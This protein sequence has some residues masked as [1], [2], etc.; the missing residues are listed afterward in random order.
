MIKTYEAF[1][2]N[3][4]YIEDLIDGYLT[5]KTQGR[6][7]L[8]REYE[9]SKNSRAGESIK[10]TRLPARV[11]SVEYLLKGSSMADMRQKLIKLNDIVNVGLAEF[12]FDDE[13]DLLY[14]GYAILTKS[15]DNKNGVNG[16]MEIHC[17][18]PFKYSIIEQEAGV[19]PDDSYS[20]LLDYQGTYESHPTLEVK[21]YEEDEKEEVLTGAG[22]CGYIA[23]FTEDEKILQFGDPDEIDGEAVQGKSETLVSQ[24]FN[25]PNDWGSTAKLLWQENTGK[26]LSNTCQTGE[27]GMSVAEYTTS[28]SFKPTSG[29]LI[30]K[31]KSTVGAPYAFY[32]V[33][34]KVVSRTEASATID[35]VITSSLQYAQSW[36]GT[37][38]GLRAD[39]YIGGSWRSVTLKS[40]SAVWRGQSGHT[41]SM[42]VTVS[43]LSAG[44]TSIS[45]I[46]FRVV[47]T[48]G[49]N[50][51]ASLS[52][53][54]VGSIS[55][56]EYRTIVPGSYFLEAKTYGSSDE[57]WHGPSI[58]RTIKPTQD[59]NLAWKMKLSIG[60]SSEDTK[61][62]GAFQIV[63]SD[64]SNKI[65]A[66]VQVIKSAD[67]KTAN[68]N[69]YVDEKL[70][71]SY[72]VDISNG[73]KVFNSQSS[74]YVSKQGEKFTFNV[75]G[76]E[77]VFNALSLKDVS[78]TRVTVCIA[79]HEDAYALS[80]NGISWIR[81]IA[82]D[83][84]TWHNLPN[85]FSSGDV[86]VIDT[87]K[88]EILLNGNPSDQLG[89]LGND[90]EDFVLKPGVNQIG[91]AYSSWVEEENA[92]EVKVKF[93]EVY[94]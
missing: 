19:S 49:M 73:N 29:T 18:D 5:V 15:S 48:D 67:G 79:K 68:V 84:G 60:N 77:K 16:T 78:V 74:E 3:G 52:E 10:D 4:E 32:T 61:Q 14:R 2:I 31:V 58:S 28:S 57:P 8:T 27:L 87:S 30:S 89:A 66:A 37:G 54:A 50:N 34:Y 83:R 92:P 51:S 7:E 12:T 70:V 33:S 94:L 53:R 25:S 65:V 22:D 47:R 81:F 44:T 90:W 43:G 36:L 40:T 93:R 35:V 23:F 17:Y 64:S 55:F 21:F 82:N 62:R 71:D 76:G 1:T 75:G 13:P 59:F 26:V 46:R 9:T 69:L 20:I 88:G 72:E 91:V 41:A 86:L 56:G 24:S 6:E 38:I 11:I 63:L 39:L 80:Y 45:G 85:K 42:R